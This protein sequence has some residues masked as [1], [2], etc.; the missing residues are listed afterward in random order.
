MPAS[1]SLKYL[2]FIFN[3]LFQTLFVG[4]FFCQFSWAVQEAIV[5]TEKAVIYSDTDTSSPIGFISKGKKILVGD[6]PRNRSRVYPV[7]VSGQIAYIKVTDVTTEKESVD[8]SRLTAERFQQSTSFRAASRFSFSYFQF[9]SQI[10]LDNENGD[11]V[12]KNI[13]NWHGL[14][15]KGESMIR[16]RIDFQV[17]INY[18]FTTFKGQAYRAS[19]FGFGGGYRFFGK[20]KLTAKVQVEALSVPFVTYSVGEDFRVISYGYTLGAGLNLNYSLKSNW[21]IHSNLGLYHTGLFSF[22]NPPPY[23]DSAPSFN[24][25]RL[26]FGVN[27]IY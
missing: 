2:R 7:I 22:D 23:K 24:G 13:F 26:S 6:A 20:K 18:M 21:G 14:S 19:E 8:S 12:D 25:N 1:K 17:I 15:L 10:R 27:Y 16:D 3:S 11:V 5:S 4:L 9:N